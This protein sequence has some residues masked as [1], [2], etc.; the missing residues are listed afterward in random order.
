MMSLAFVDEQRGGRLRGNDVLIDDELCGMAV[1]GIGN[2][3]DIV[4]ARWRSRTDLGRERDN[5]C[6]AGVHLDRIARNA[7]ALRAG[8][9]TG[10]EEG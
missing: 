3:A 1:P 7:G 9:E 10:S 8:R 6:I 2:R 5:S 4:L